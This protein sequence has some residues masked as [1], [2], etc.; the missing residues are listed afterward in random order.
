MFVHFVAFLYIKVKTE[1]KA[2]KK[3]SF[4]SIKYDH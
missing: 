1:Q 2:K 3:I 4:R